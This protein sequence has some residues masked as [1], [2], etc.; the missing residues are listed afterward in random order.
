M[1][2]ALWLRGHVT[3]LFQKCDT[4][5]VVG[6]WQSNDLKTDASKR[7]LSGGNNNSVMK[8]V[9]GVGLLMLSLAA[10]AATQ[11]VRS[12]KPYTE[13]TRDEVIRI[14]F[15]SQWTKDS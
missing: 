3:K 4:I 7:L 11:T 8:I 5:S 12:M 15:N 9:V 6:R 2:Y 10:T 1:T 13:W 14:L